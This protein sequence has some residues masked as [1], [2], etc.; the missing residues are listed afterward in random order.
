MV[1]VRERR[2]DKKCRSARSGVRNRT[3]Q[4]VIPNYGSALDHTRPKTVDRVGITLWSKILSMRGVG[5]AG[6]KPLGK[7]QDG[8]LLRHLGG[9]CGLRARLLRCPDG[10]KQQRSATHTYGPALG[11][12]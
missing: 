7:W 4:R 11:Q 12:Q 9:S 1:N 5:E 6:S 10:P 3:C 2:R 8:R